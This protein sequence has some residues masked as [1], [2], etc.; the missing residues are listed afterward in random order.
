[1]KSVDEL[2]MAALRRPRIVQKVKALAAARHWGE[3]VGEPLAGMAEVSSSDAFAV[4]MLM[5]RAQG[6]TE[7]HMFRLVSSVP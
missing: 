7:S 2:L 1:M 3:A 4:P 5:V 6:T